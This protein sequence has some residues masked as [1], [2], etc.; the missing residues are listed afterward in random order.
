MRA[1]RYNLWQHYPC[2]LEFQSLPFSIK[3][4]HPSPEPSTN[5]FSMKYSLL[6]V[7]FYTMAIRSLLCLLI[8]VRLSAVY[9][10]LYPRFYDISCP[11]ALSIVNSVVTQAVA[12]EKRMGASLLRL[13][14]HDCFVNVMFCLIQLYCPNLCRLNFQLYV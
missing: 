7:S 11:S 13:H 12:K 1:V 9:G 14:F 2:Y 3:P 6:R 5:S 8:L 10:Q 4:D